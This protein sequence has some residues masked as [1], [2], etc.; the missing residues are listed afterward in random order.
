MKGKDITIICLFASSLILL[1]LLT[2]TQLFVTP[3]PV[4]AGSMQASGGDYIATIARV[5]EGEEA[6]WVL[7][8]RTK[9][10]GIYQY[11]NGSRSLE[12]RTTF[13][14]KELGE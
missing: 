11:D 12:L 3:K 4:F 9:T 1:T 5:T 2:L 8:C 10:V 13:T 14:V 6:L 7:D